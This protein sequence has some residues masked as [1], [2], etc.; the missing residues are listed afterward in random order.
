M[1]FKHQYLN[2]ILDSNEVA[3]TAQSLYL[4]SLA[5]IVTK[6]IFQS[7]AI[8]SFDVSTVHVKMF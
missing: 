1:S 6:Y 8:R 3:G 4:T 5:I 7:G 2:I